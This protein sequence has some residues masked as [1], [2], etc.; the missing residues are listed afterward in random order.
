M[1]KSFVS[2][3]I[4]AVTA[5]SALLFSSGSALASCANTEWAN[6]NPDHPLPTI[7]ARLCDQDMS[8]NVIGAAPDGSVFDFGWSPAV[9]VSPDSYTS[10]F[11]DANATNS[12][13]MEIDRDANTMRLTI[14]TQLNDDSN[15]TQ[16]FAD[17]TLTSEYD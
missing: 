1:P 13:L 11:V 17:Y 3:S 4:L 14:D 5:I 9:Q 12:I 10:S 7:T 2:N 6:V 15:V 16:W 8:L